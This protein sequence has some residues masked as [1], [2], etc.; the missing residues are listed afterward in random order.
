MSSWI[1][2]GEKQM[3]EM[4]FTWGSEPKEKWL[5]N[6]TDAAKMRANDTI[7]V[8]FA[9]LEEFTQDFLP[10]LREDFVLI[11]TAFHLMYPQGI[12]VLAREIVAHPYL[13]CWF[14]TNVGSYTGGYQQHAKVAPF[15]LG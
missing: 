3:K 14:S 8:S 13:L 11:T 4:Y 12:E 9:K 5:S 2:H 10:H 7:F 1:Y 6:G 15:P